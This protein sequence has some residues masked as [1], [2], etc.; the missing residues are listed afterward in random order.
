[1]RGQTDDAG[2]LDPD[3]RSAETVRVGRKEA[4]QVR[5]IRQD[6]RKVSAGSGGRGRRFR[7]DGT[8][9]LGRGGRPS[10]AGD[11]QLGRGLPG[12]ADLVAF[13]L[14]ALVGARRIAARDG[15]DARSVDRIGIEQQR[16]QGEDLEREQEGQGGEP[17]RA[18]TPAAGKERVPHGRYFFSSFFFFKK[19]RPKRMAPTARAA[20]AAGFS[21]SPKTDMIIDR[22]PIIG[23]RKDVAPSSRRVNPPVLIS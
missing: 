6:R 12:D 19:E 9:A 14:A 3:R 17:G 15:A 21:Y 11:D 10:F 20:M 22:R 18:T 8:A 16:G 13:P 7:R 2:G 23:K 4:L 5:R 1:M